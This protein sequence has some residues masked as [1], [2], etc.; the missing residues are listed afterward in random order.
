MADWKIEY[1]ILDRMVN[2]E[3]LFARNARFVS[4]RW[5]RESPP[6]RIVV[7]IPIQRTV[8]AN[9]QSKFRRFIGTVALEDV[10]IQDIE[11][12]VQKLVGRILGKNCDG[13]K[14]VFL[15]D[16]PSKSILVG[17]SKGNDYSQFHF[18]AGEASIIEMVTSIEDAPHNSL[19]LIEEI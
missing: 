6:D 2:K 7:S 17:A 4:A 12:S 5:R 11:E 16:D 13:Y 1:D 10:V 14:R 18:G 3:S 8:P 9:E 15:P 19:I